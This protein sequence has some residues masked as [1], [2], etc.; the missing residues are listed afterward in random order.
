MFT[1]LPMV[2]IKGAGDLATG[3]AWRLR[4]CGFPVVMTE[5]PEPTT[6]RRNAAFS[7]AVYEGMVTVEGVTAQLLEIPAQIYASLKYN[8]IPVV[9]DPQAAIIGE[10][11]PEIVVDAIIAKRNTGT[12]IDDAPLVIGLGPGFSAGT[13]VHRVIETNRGHNL[14]RVIR[15]G[16]A[17][18]NT[19]I[20][21]IVN[22]HGIERV[23]RSPAD[24]FMM[25]YCMIGDYMEAGDVLAK[26]DGIAVLAPFSGTIR[27]LL[28][29]NIAA[30]RGMKI[31]DI[32]PRRC[33]EL[34]GKISEKALAI[35]G[36]VLEVI[37]TYLN[38]KLEV[39]QPRQAES[40]EMGE[41]AQEPSARVLCR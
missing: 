29:E 39:S 7:E 5:V 26:V 8:L 41:R 6:V 13:D 10:L 27:G 34:C 3:V 31:G 33:P 4:R 30:F 1:E 12:Q 21:G 18:P 40:A 24:G 19:G 35:A 23:L 9:V 28:R 20:P 37:V 2:L 15:K 22:G 38:A 17:E 32:D 25:P 36:G 16:S 11:K 14:G